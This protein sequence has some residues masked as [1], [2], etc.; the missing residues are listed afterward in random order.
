MRVQLTGRQ[1]RV[2]EGIVLAELGDEAVLLNVDTGLYYGLGRAELVVWGLVSEGAPE[3]E[4]LA[5]LLDEFEVD[6]RQLEA[7]L[8]EFLDCARGS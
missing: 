3:E 1:F 4:I 2:N 8:S 5:R 7:D 6:V